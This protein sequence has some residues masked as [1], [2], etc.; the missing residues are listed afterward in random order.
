MIEMDRFLT[1]KKERMKLTGLFIE[2]DFHLQLCFALEAL[3]DHRSFL[4]FRFRAIEKL[5]SATPLHDLRS[6]ESCQLAETVRAINDRVERRNLCIS[7]H[8]VAV[9]EQRRIFH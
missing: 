3:V 8:K 1:R 2:Y 9:C 6:R 7:Q 4:F 5:A